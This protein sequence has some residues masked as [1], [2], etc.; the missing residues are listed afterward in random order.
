MEVKEKILE[1]ASALFTQYGV[2]S[3][4]MDEIAKHLSVSKRTLYQ[5]FRD[6]HELVSEVIHRDLTIDKQLCDEICSN[7][8]NSIEELFEISKFF[9]QRILKIN[10]SLMYVLQKYHHQAWE[11]YLDF[12]QNVFLNSLI[13]SL[14]RGIGEGYIRKSINAEILA[15][16]RM[17]EVQMSFDQSVFPRDRFDFIEIQLQF[18]EYF[19]NGIITEKGRKLIAKYS[20]KIV[21]Q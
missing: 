12:K 16:L 13:K 6:K 19:V 5:Y 11:I 8:A 15:T 1:A 7:A 20:D 21:L 10:P 3:V 18:F 4:T 9:R 2:K 14:Q 17:E